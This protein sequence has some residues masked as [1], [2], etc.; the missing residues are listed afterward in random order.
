MLQIPK[1]TMVKITF[2]FGEELTSPPR[3]I[4]PSDRSAAED[5]GSRRPVRCG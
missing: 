3:E 1:D 5:G 4:P 2:V